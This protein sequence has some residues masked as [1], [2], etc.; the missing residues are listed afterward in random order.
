MDK[1]KLAAA[2]DILYKIEAMEGINS[3]SIDY[4][5]AALLKALKTWGIDT[6]ILFKTREEILVEVDKKKKELEKEFENL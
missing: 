3:E 1:A 4:L 6:N 5:L 2:Q